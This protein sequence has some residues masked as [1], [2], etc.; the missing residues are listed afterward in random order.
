MKKV[1]ICSPYRGDTETNIENA[2]K[3][4]RAVVELGYLPIAPHLFFPQ[5]MDDDNPEEREV[6]IEM[7][8]EL[9]DICAEVW[10]FGMNDPSEGMSEEIHWA[11]DAGIPVLDGLKM[12]GK[13]KKKSTIGDA[14]DDE[15]VGELLSRIRNGRIGIV[16]EAHQGGS[17][18]RFEVRK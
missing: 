6:A 15:L 16:A 3:Y 17:N 9:I 2:R 4:C 14:S 11:E 10:V 12:I 1:Y 8:F 18:V 7:D 13:N 5:F